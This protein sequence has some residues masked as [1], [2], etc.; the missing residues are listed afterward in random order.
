MNK[1]SKS[2]PKEVQEAVQEE[3]HRFNQKN[4]GRED[5]YYEVR[6]RG[7]HCY[8]DRSDFGRLGPICRLT[9]KG[10]VDDWDFSIFKWSSERYDPEEW[11]FPGSELVD[12]TVKG[13]MRA[14]L[15]A[16][17]V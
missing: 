9:Y 8:L 12:G 16:Y 10:A 5:C 17:P 3:V 14:G 13:A 2:I 6:F 15:E 11:M 4:S 7:K 1:K